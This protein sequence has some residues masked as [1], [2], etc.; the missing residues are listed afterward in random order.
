MRKRQTE[1]SVEKIAMDRNTLCY[2]I[3]TLAKSLCIKRHCVAGYSLVYIIIHLSV[4]NDNS[5][6]SRMI[7]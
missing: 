3:P 5:K 6:Y 4:S 7:H 2:C 1:P